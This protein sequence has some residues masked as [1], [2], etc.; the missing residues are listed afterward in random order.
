MPRELVIALLLLAGGPALAQD[1]AAGLLACRRHVEAGPRLACY[2]AL[3]AKGAAMEFR[4][5]GNQITPPF[6]LKAPANLVFESM[7]AILV[8]Y[9]LDAAGA[10]VQN[11]HQAGAGAGRFLIEHPGRYSLQVNA[12]G[13]WRMRIEAP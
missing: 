6:D 3:P 9:L 4:G 8:I 11:L 2:D 1:M 13:G 7:D 12:S 10:V 5:T